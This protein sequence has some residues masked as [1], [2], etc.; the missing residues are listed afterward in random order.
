MKRSTLLTITLLSTLCT[1]RA[2]SDN[3]FV[4]ISG[5]NLYKI[6]VQSCSTSF[7][8]PTGF[9]FGDIAMTPSGELYGIVS[10]MI[11]RIDTTD[12]S[13]SYI[14]QTTAPGVSLVALDNT[15]LLAEFGLDLFAISTID[16]STNFV[17]NIGYGASGDLTW[18]D[19]DL[20]KSSGGHMIRITSNDN[21]N[22]IS[23]VAPVS[24]FDPNWLSCE[25]IATAMI[26][27]ELSSIVGFRYPDLLC[28]SPIDGSYQ[29]ICQPPLPGGVPGAA[30]IP[31]VGTSMYGCGPVGIGVNELNESTRL[32][33]WVASGQLNMRMPMG[34][35]A[36]NVV[37]RDVSGRIVHHVAMNGSSLSSVDL[38]GLAFG[39]Y[40]V[41]VVSVR[42]ILTGRFL[43]T[44][45]Q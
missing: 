24:A 17:G 8:G 3:F 16:A 32:Q 30:S 20:Y 41:E 19:G 2:Q 13:T 18:Y 38:T 34:S 15:T 7:V 27:D 43:Y 31:P 14:G 35:T 4:T 36:V 42:G 11:Y 10:G 45:I 25:G 37:V 5:G 39:P 44:G 28:Y 21:F 40:T 23:S 6:H 26:T 12:A 22:S 29:T 33:L 9:G 1:L